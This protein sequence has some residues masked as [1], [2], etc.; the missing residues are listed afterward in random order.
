MKFDIEYIILFSILVITFYMIGYVLLDTEHYC[1]CTEKKC[2]SDEQIVNY[3]NIGEST[4][5]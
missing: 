4:R 1:G 2:Y 3:A 5:I